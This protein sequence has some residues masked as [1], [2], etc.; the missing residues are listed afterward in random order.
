M[1]W[2]YEVKMSAWGAPNTIDN[3]R[4]R[5][6]QKNLLNMHYGA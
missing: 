6:L 4:V 5:A 3:A 2:I 1:H